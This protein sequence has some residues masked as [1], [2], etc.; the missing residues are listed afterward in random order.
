MKESFEQ[1]EPEIN[2]EEEEVLEVTSNQNSYARVALGKNRTLNLDGIFLQFDNKVL[3]ES[4]KLLLLPKHIYG[5]VGK[6]GS[7]KTSLLRKL[8]KKQIQGFPS[9]ITTS[10]CEQEREGNEQTVLQSML[11]SDPEIEVL[12]KKEK[13]V[14]S[15]LENNIITVKNAELNFTEINLK[16]EMKDLRKMEVRAKHLLKGFGFDEEMHSLETQSLSGGYR[17]KLALAMALFQN[18]D[19]LC[20]D[21]PTN[22]LDIENKLFL[23]H[24]L[25]NHFKGTILVVSHDT[26]FLDS[27]CTDVIE[28]RKKTLEYFPGNFSEYEMIK[29]DREKHRKERYVKQQRKITQSKEKM[30]KVV[31]M[32]LI[33]AKKSKKKKD[34]KA[35][36]KG[37]KQL[38]S[39]IDRAI[40]IR[41]ENGKRYH[42]SYDGARDL[43][44]EE[45]KEKFKVFKLHKCSEELE[46][47]ALQVNGVYFSHSGE[48]NDYLFKNVNLS[49]NFGEKIAIIGNNGTGKTTFLD[50]LNRSIDPTQG[51]INHH[52]NIKVSHFTQHHVQQLDLNLTPL[53]HLVKIFPIEKEDILRSHLAKFGIVEYMPLQK[54]KNF[55]GGEKSRVVFAT[56]T[57]SE[58]NVLILDEISNHLDL[59]AQISIINSLKDFN[60]TIIMV[61]HDQNLISSVAEKFFLLENQFIKELDISF[62]EYIESKMEELEEGFEDEEEY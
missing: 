19:V 43:L 28:L 22:H 17:Q 46:G 25:R 15:D 11:E 24:Y 6:N 8:Y 2:S 57:L 48:N 18:A 54:M 42:E 3:I 12:K 16:L 56:I 44:V 39:K 35:S 5:L 14:Q 40:Y 45:K 13:K 20:L 1:I 10:F 4:A 60:G 52:R 38:Q 41:P 7:G 58:P 62:E 55:S 9:H 26:V 59:E 61:S 36:V 49:V 47:T 21:E 51:S 32:N 29:E 30:E 27:I 37:I 50:L 34:I 53:E 31:N 23:S 33:K